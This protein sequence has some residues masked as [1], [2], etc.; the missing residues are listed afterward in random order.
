MVPKEC[1][2]NPSIR[3]SMNG[4]YAGQC[5]TVHVCLQNVYP[6]KDGELIGVKH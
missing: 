1:R 6:T 4:L 5:D 2:F 3:E